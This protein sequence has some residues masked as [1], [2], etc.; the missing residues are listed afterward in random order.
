MAPKLTA[1]DLDGIGYDAMRSERPDRF[2]AE[3]VDAVDH[4]RLA[5]PAETG[6][7]LALA[8]EITERSRGAEEAVPLAARRVDTTAGTTEHTAARAQHAEL[9]LRC[10]RDDE[11]MRELHELRPRLTRDALEAAT[12]IEVLTENGRAELAEQWLTPAVATALDVAERAER[13]APGSEAADDAWGTA[14]RLAVH[15]RGIRHELGLAPD[16]TDGFADEILAA[17]EEGRDLEFW[18]ASAFA[19]VRAAFP[20]GE[21][22]AETD[23]DAHRTA[24]ERELQAGDAE[25][26]PPR[27]EVATPE[28]LAAVLAGDDDAVAP[29]PLLAWPPGR[30]EPCWC[31]S[32]TKYKKCCLP[33]GRT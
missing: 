32:Q 3:L 4:D 12:I 10:G 17:D 11:G 14:E 19:E 33:R 5:D 9:L 6:Y 1:D 31:G 23:W 25:G 15:R 7:A 28:L 8:A 26:D 20:Q 30:N 27:V 21:V 29:G 2:V 22:V 24:I 13:D 16:A 18:P